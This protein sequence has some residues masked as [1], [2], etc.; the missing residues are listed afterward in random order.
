MDSMTASSPPTGDTHAELTTAF[1]SI[2]VPQPPSPT[3]L[4]DAIEAELR[5]HG[6][7]LRWAITSVDAATRRVEVEAVVTLTRTQA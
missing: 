4:R 1:L 6:D 5:S 7:P 2:S 3:R